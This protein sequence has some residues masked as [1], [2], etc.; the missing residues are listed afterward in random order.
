MNDNKVTVLAFVLFLVCAALMG[1]VYL[2][3]GQLVQLHEE[4][5]DL[6]QRGGELEQTMQSLVEQKQVFTDAFRALENYQVRVAS[7]DM[8]F[9]S[10]VQG[11]V[12]NTGVEISSTQ[13]KGTSKDGRSSLALTLRGDYYKFAEVLAKWRN[14]STTV[15]VAAMTITASRTPETRGEVQVDVTVEAIIGK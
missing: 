6:V 13:Q 3:N 5:A 4:Y 9:Y 10:E 2:L 14:L 11:A 12:Q 15:R 7:S 8:V 1:G